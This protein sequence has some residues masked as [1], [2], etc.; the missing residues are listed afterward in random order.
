[1][2]P[3]K[4]ITL[5]VLIALLAVACAP[6]AEEP[7]AEP[8]VEP[9]VK[10]ETEATVG[11]TADVQ[12]V[13]YEALVEALQTE[14]ATVE[15]VAEVE[16]PFFGVDGQLIS[17]NGTEVQVFEYADEAARQADS[18]K[19]SPDGSSIGTTMVTWVDQPNFWAEGRLIVLYVGQDE[20]ILNL[21]SN[22][23]GTR[24]NEEVVAPAR[25]EEYP[26]AVI[27]ARQDLSQSLGIPAD[28]IEV[29]SHEEVEWPD[30]CL[31]LAEPDEMCAQVI[32]PGWRVILNAEGQQF[33]YHTDQRGKIIRRKEPMTDTNQSY[34][35][36]VRAAVQRLSQSLDVAADQIEVISYQQVEWPDACLGLAS[37]DEMCAQVI[38]PGWEIMLEAAGRTYEVHTNMTGSSVRWR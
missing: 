27:A 5:V 33:E 23:L 17:V 18:E 21:F 20:D 8:P 28:Q 1:M 22:I 19:I 29:V 10:P 32:T 34:P 7:G 31:G 37:A 38:T 3:G 15:P 13:D 12:A 6:Q 9:T 30:A 36:A 14:G 2:L 25:E 4:V 24:I 35:E 16:Q 26:P 11:P